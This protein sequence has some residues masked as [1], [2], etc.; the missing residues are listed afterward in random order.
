MSLERLTAL[1]FSHEGK[2]VDKWEQYLAVYAGE[3]ARFVSNGL[4]V[5]LLEIGV[6]NGGSL[7][8]WSKYLP[9]GSEVIGLDI[10]PAVDKLRFEGQVVAKIAD[11]NDTERLGSLLGP[12]LFDIIIDDGSHQSDDIV[13]AFRSLFDKLRPGGIFVVEDLHAS[14]WTTHKGGL[15]RDGSAVEFFKG[16]VDSLAVDHF[17]STTAISDEALAELQRFGRWIGRV[18]FYDSI[19]VVQKSFTEKTK[20]YRRM[21]S[22]ITAEVVDPVEGLLTSPPAMVQG[23]V[24]GKAVGS[25]LN[26]ELLAR[27]V[28]ALQVQ[29]DLKASAASLEAKLEALGV[30]DRLERERD[31]DRH[32][33]A[34]ELLRIEH[35]S[36]RASLELLVSQL[37]AERDALLRSVWWKGAPAYRL[38]KRG[39][40]VVRRQ[41][42]TLKPNVEEATPAAA[43]PKEI[44]R[45]ETTANARMI[46]ESGL[47]D[48][49][50]YQATYPVA[51][52]VDPIRHYLTVGAPAGF[53]PNPLFDTLWYLESNKDVRQKGINPLLHYIQHGAHEGRDPNPYFDSDWF[54]TQN[55]DVRDAG[56]NPLRHYLHHGAGE[57][58]DPSPGFWSRWYRE[59]Y[60]KDVDNRL[61]PLEHYI[62]YGR[63]AGYEPK[64]PNAGYLAEILKKEQTLAAELGEI[65]QH[66]KSMVIRPRFFIRLNGEDPAA[67]RETEHSLENQLYPD[68]SL[69][70]SLAEIFEQANETATSPWFFLDIDAGDRLHSSALYRFASTIN[71]DPGVDL[72]YSDEDNL[73][74]DGVRN[75]PFFKPD[76][77][78]D[79]LESMNYIGPVA[80]FRGALAKSLL[81]RGSAGYDLILKITELT[82]NIQHVRQ[83][84]FHR[85]VESANYGSPDQIEEDI[86]ALKGR[87]HRTGR[88]G[89]IQPIGENSRC[90]DVKIHLSKTPMVSIIIPT[91]G[92][93]ID[94]GGRSVDLLT[95]CLDSIATRSSYKN[96]EL[97]II[98][99]GDL[100]S[101]QIAGLRRHNA[102]VVTF[103]ER[104]FNVAK[105]LNLGASVAKG[106]FLLLLNDDIEP[107]NLDWIERLLEHFEKPQV[108]VVGAKLLY[109][110]E[111]TQHVGVVLNSGNP[112][113]V[114]RSRPRDDLG[115]Y[116]STAAVRNFVGVTGACM[117]TRSSHF[118]QLSGYSETLAISF[119]DV[120]FCLRTLESGLTVVYAPKAE[121][122]HFE[123]RSRIPS[124]DMGEL[125]YFYKRWSHIVSDPFYNES[126]LA[127]APPTYEVKHN[128]R[129]I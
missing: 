25:R 52:E 87:L 18:S 96:L 81:E 2:I 95:N 99:N 16:L 129:M 109:P 9:S 17:D 65:R 50:W 1:F 61:N 115:Y 118:K 113:H 23:L 91:A 116:F 43:I 19:V 86:R 68:W 42:K 85:R 14:Y 15:R 119:N 57:D 55:E 84:L 4:P 10:D 107:L 122:T 126:E 56:I 3:F 36:E 6:Q 106:D 75:R 89:V 112:D 64:S 88:D 83:I 41:I 37:R 30:Q 33:S 5:R 125:E 40:Q 114:R 49:E 78:P 67:R 123:S 63:A 94:F 110:D 74:A 98:D 8:L 21:L 22:G 101:S 120:D 44:D 90:Y 24:L 58:R 47:F 79:Y 76:W 59:R 100:T 80:C 29:G 105:K 62:R 35:A 39:E 66:I 34:L 82:R 128:N 38:L 54:L 104:K 12:E 108:G 102:R 7:E 46:Q 69:L 32:N 117:M 103:R 45:K 27:L 111:T 51:R 93:V 48:V 124:L 77:S 28:N 70:A 20:S 73:D 127:A 13:S 71:A 92:N 53:K 60:L 31:Q 26:S 72:I 121:L 97:V 11:V